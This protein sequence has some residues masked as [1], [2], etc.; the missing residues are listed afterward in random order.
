MKKA[1][2]I[3]FVALVVCIFNVNFASKSNLAKANKI[4]FLNK[5]LADSE[6]YPVPNPEPDPDNPWPWPTPSPLPDPGTPT[7]L[8]EP[9]P[10]PGPIY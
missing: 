9:L 8:P 7:P 4:V 5:A 6:C 1:V 3:S 10:A 2:I